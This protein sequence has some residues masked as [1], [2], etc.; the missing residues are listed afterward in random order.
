MSYFTYS[1]CLQE[2]VLQRKVVNFVH[3]FYNGV[4]TI[5]H[6]QP[7]L[8]C[9][10]KQAL[11]IS[12]ARFD[13]FGVIPSIVDD[14][15]MSGGHFVFDRRAGGKL[16]RLLKF[17][18]Q[19]KETPGYSS[20]GDR[21]ADVIVG[22]NVYAKTPHRVAFALLLNIIR[23]RWWPALSYNDEHGLCSYICETLWSSGLTRTLMKSDVQFDTCYKLIEAEF[24]FL[25]PWDDPP[26]PG[27]EEGPELSSEGIPLSVLDISLD[28]LGLS[29]STSMLLERAGFTKVG[30]ILGLSRRHFLESGFLKDGSLQD[31]E[32]GLGWLGLSLPRE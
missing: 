32:E 21:K 15:S 19:A 24:G 29:V 9:L 10:T 8:T 3:T 18:G 2:P 14:G 16:I 12:E 27:V 17:P 28:H 30:Q 11:E 25:L 7:E 26:Q 23:L 1:G 22:E 6:P 31:L 13:Y 5:V 4:A 20:P